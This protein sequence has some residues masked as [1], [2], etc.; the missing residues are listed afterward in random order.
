VVFTAACSEDAQ[1]DSE[2]QWSL[3]SGL[4]KRLLQYRTKRI[5]FVIQKYA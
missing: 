2:Y 5:N 1:D 4:R 3:A